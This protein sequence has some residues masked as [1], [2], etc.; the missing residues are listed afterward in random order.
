MLKDT[1]RTEGYRDFI[2]DNKHLFKD[3]VGGLC[4]MLVGRVL[5]T[6]NAIGCA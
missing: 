1:V 2:Y 5:L 4:A 3:K 6:W